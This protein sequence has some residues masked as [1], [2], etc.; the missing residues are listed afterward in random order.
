MNRIERERQ[1][2]EHM[3]KMYCRVLHGTSWGFCGECGPLLEYAHLRLDR[4]PFQEGKPVCLHCK[5]HCYSPEMREKIREV[6]HF[7]GPR[8]ML[9]HPWL[10]F[11]HLW[12]TLKCKLL[13]APTLKKGN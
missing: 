10:S 13:G 11:M 8:L 6:M 7:A 5:V 2:I 12:D 9:R 1:T 4:C 3:I